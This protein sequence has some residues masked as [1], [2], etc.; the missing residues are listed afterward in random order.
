MV[1]PIINILVFGDFVSSSVALMP[2]HCN[3]SCEI[4]SETIVWKF[5]IPLAS[6]CFL[7]ASFLFQDKIHFLHFLFGLQ[8]MA[9]E[10]KNIYNTSIFHTQIY[11]LYS[12]QIFK[13]LY[14][15]VK[16]KYISKIKDFD[17][18]FYEIYDKY[19]NYH[20]QIKPF[21][22]HNNDFIY[23]FIKNRINGINLVNNNYF[24]FEE[25]II[26]TLEK[27]NSLKFPQNCTIETKRE[28]FYDIAI[29][30]LKSIYNKNFIKTKEEIL[31]RKKCT[32]NDPSFIDQVRNNKHLFSKESKKIDYKSLLKNH[33]L[34]QNLEK[35]KGI[36]SNQNYIARI[37]YNYYLNPKIPSDLMCNIIAKAFQAYNSFFALRKKGIKA[38]IPKFL[39]RNGSFILPFFT[40]SRKEVKLGNH[41][42]YRLTVGSYISNNYIS[43]IDDNRMICIDS[44]KENKLYIDS[45][46][47][48]KIDPGEKIYKTQ[49][50]IINEYYVPKKSKHI[51]EGYY[52]YV[53]KPH[54]MHDKKIKLIE[55]CA[56]YDGFKF[57]INYVYDIKKTNNKSKKGKCISIDFGMINIATIYDPEGSQ[58]I[59]KGTGLISFNNHINAKIDK[60]KSELSKNKPTKKNPNEIYQKNINNWVDY[61]NGKSN[62]VPIRKTRND[63]HNQMVKKEVNFVMSNNKIENKKQ[64]TSIRIRELLIYRKNKIEDILNKIVNTISKKYSNCETVIVGYNEG[65]KTG[66]NMGRS[67][68]RDFYEIPYRRLINKL[69]DKLEKNNQKLEIIEESYTS[70]CDALSLEKICRH[71]E[72]L[73]KRVK[74]GLFS[75]KTG[76]LLNAD[77][78]GAINI[79]RK[80]KEKNNIKMDKITGKNICNPSK[81]NIHEA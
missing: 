36:K 68:N 47:L 32:I 42:Y 22:K 27:N 65:W 51:M 63:N 21:K 8:F 7:S 59:I 16:K 54:L 44:S 74:R 31:K 10:S 23:A 35:G 39:D 77:L 2:F 71:Q 76:V 56:Q 33:K 57:K 48:I 30:I 9:H 26:K 15:L 53:K 14:Q 78:N 79:M 17:S 41:Y 49:N 62:F 29:S 1:P 38:N 64:L 46:Y 81:L 25:Y 80:W 40:R 6:I 52:I 28:L 34:F 55:I 5:L 24:M 13:E 58:H 50:Y 20:L 4:P 66:V 3:S 72:Y 60:A 43:I 11:L 73:G 18:K 37:V 69:R 75:S 45:K 19:Y 61:I 70:K 67:N 12:N